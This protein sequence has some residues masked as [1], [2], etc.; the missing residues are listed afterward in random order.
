[1]LGEPS[2][3][4]IGCAGSSKS[5]SGSFHLPCTRSPIY[6]LHCRPIIG[7]DT[8]PVS[9]RIAPSVLKSSEYLATAT[10]VFSLD[11]LPLSTNESRISPCANCNSRRSHAHLF[12]P[13]A[14]LENAAMHS[15]PSSL[16]ASPNLTLLYSST[17][18]PISKTPQQ[19]TLHPPLLSPRLRL[20]HS[21]IAAFPPHLL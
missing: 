1:M 21:F 7:T 4:F 13:S 9:Y 2:R 3:R 12:S 15:L 16:I 19:Q 5:H 17:L 18:A 11:S 20:K 6:I 10:V 14:L 8:F